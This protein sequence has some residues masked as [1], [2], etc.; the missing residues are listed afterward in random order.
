MGFKHSPHIF[1][2]VLCN[3][4]EGLSQILKSV[5]IQYM[6]NIIICSPDRETCYEDLVKLLQVLAQ[7]GHKV[8]QK[9]LQYVQ[10]QVIYLGQ[11]ITNGVSQTAIWKQFEEHQSPG[12][13]GK[14]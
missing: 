9:K 14:L 5:V 13:P 7:K 6:D 1:N 10:E 11:S 4:L 3:D 8:S 12:Q 2:K